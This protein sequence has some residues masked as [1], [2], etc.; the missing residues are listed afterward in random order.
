MNNKILASQAD[1]FHFPCV[2]RSNFF[3]ATKNLRKSTI[4]IFL[5]MV[6]VSFVREYIFFCE[7]ISKDDSQFHWLAPFSGVFTGW[8]ILATLKVVLLV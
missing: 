7:K 8:K 6:T 3:F 1:Y 2:N 4:N 5:V